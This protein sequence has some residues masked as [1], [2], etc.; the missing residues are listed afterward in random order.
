M[1]PNEVPR[2]WGQNIIFP[3][4]QFTIVRIPRLLSTATNCFNGRFPVTKIHK[5]YE[6]YVNEKFLPVGT[7]N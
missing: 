6:P 2:R 5:S 3:S 1:Q 4:L 7:A